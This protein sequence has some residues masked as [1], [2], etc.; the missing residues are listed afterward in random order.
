MVDQMST[1]ISRM[2]DDVKQKQAFSKDLGINNMN[3]FI[4]AQKMYGGGQLK[5]RAQEKWK[6]NVDNRSK[7]MKKDKKKTSKLPADPKPRNQNV[8]DYQ[9]NQ[10][11]TPR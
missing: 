6:K 11:S 5:K 9:S 4:L 7:V 8:R 10:V 3:S 2:V 1:Y